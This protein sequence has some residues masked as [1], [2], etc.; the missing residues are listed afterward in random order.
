MINHIHAH[1][2]ARRNTHRLTRLLIWLAV[3]LVAAVLTGCRSG[4][5]SPSV[6]QGSP[7]GSGQ[8]ASAG[9][10]QGPGPGQGS[11][12][13]SGSGA[14]SGEAPSGEAPSGEAPSGG[15]DT[16]TYVP[17]SGASDNLNEVIN[18]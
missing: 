9:S 6:A 3:L 8:G 15:D 17:P 2:P 10:G 11:P 4:V 18:S 12:D 16:G 1:S 13:D 5:S 14:P 7:P